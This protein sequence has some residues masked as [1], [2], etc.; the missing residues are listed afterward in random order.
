MRLHSLSMLLLALC[1]ACGSDGEPGDGGSSGADAATSDNGGSDSASADSLAYDGWLSPDATPDGDA[2]DRDGSDSA[3]DVPNADVTPSDSSAD[4]SYDDIVPPAPFALLAPV[5]PVP[6]RP[7]PVVVEWTDGSQW[8]GPA[9]LAWDGSRT[10]VRV[11]R[12]RASATLL[13]PETPGDYPLD[14]EA[15]GYLSGEMIEV[16]A[17]PVRALTG[18]LSGDALHWTASE[19]IALT[20]D[21]DVPAGEELVVEAGTRVLMGPDARLRVQGGAT[22]AGTESDPVLFAPSAAH[23][24]EVDVR[25]DAD[26]RY[27]YFVGGG[28]D[29]SRAFGHSDSQPVVRAVEAD[30]FM[31][32]GG[33]LDSPGKAFGS[34][35][36]RVQILDVTVARC[37]TGGEFERT[38]LTLTGS[39]FTELPD[40]DG[41]AD[42][43][44]NDGIYL[45]DALLDGQGNP[46]T[47]RVE[48]CVFSLGEDDG[49]DH[50]EAEVEIRNTWIEGFRHEGIAASVGRRVLVS[51]TVV[52]GC[53]QGIESGYGSPEVIVEHCVIAD[54]EVGLRFGDDYDWEDLG[55]LTVSHSIVQNNEENVRNYSEPVG[56]PIPEALLITCSVLDDDAWAGTGAN[57]QASVPWFV[58]GCTAIPPRLDSGMCGD[59]SPGLEGCQ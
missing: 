25:G 23:W 55:T 3:S 32:G 36:S 37:D 31:R 20:G 15:N 57:V 53:Q 39:W 44:D 28:G 35:D 13:A 26:L 6:G 12:G 17:R 56:G 14:I 27:A 52:V 59:S 50:N 8:S 29:P 7:F 40:S 10:G 43:D 58:S 47:S 46:E 38:K 30:L 54:N 5:T 22:V 45:R 2:L 1:C 9:T 41:I 24:G 48:E 16:R 33:V 34:R 18:S 42:D 49:I 51:N 21:A 4:G 11:I 19:D